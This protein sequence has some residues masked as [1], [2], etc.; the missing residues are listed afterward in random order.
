MRNKLF[1]FAVLWH[2]NEKETKEGLKS[3]IIVPKETT[4][5]KD[6]A[7]VNL[8]VAMGIPGEY[9]DTLD[10]VEIVVRPF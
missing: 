6:I 4:L 10:Q 3:K 5:A 7:E 1:E 2:P 9:K 8:K